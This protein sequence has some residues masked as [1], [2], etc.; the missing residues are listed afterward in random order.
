MTITP[1][2]SLALAALKAEAEK[3]NMPVEIIDNKAVIDGGKVVEVKEENETPLNEVHTQLTQREMANLITFRMPEVIPMA[4]Y[5]NGQ[6]RR[7]ERRA[8]ERNNKKK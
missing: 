8:K 7:R 5:R 4:D 3:H 6:E 1:K 2:M